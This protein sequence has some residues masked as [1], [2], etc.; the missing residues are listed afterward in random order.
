MGIK[1]IRSFQLDTPHGMVVE[2]R[3][4]SDVY[5]EVFNQPAVVKEITQDQDTKGTMIWLEGEDRGR[6][7][8]EILVLKSPL[9]GD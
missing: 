1:S 4:G 2:I 7:P 6:H 5:D 8:W 9:D 3:P